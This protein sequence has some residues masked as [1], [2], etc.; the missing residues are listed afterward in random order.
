MK[1]DL[2]KF[3][4]SLN[5]KVIFEIKQPRRKADYGVLNEI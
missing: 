1:I 5:N 3:S 4:N 2:L